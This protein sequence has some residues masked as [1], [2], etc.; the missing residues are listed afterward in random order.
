MSAARALAQEGGELVL[1][2]TFRLA[3]AA[4]AVALA[5]DRVRG[6][7]QPQASPEATETAVLL[8]SE[9]VTN[10]VKYGAGP[11]IVMVVDLTDPVRVEIHDTSPGVLPRLKEPV[12][13]PGGRGL[14]LVDRLA[15]AWGVSATAGGKSVWF[16]MS[17]S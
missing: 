13:G 5:R 16:R 10:A 4:Q 1:E 15:D 17:P 6:L 14:L 12:E 8:V 3:A 9:L 7:L 2:H 11:E